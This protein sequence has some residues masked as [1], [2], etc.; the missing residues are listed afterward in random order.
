MIETKYMKD[1][2]KKAF[3]NFENIKASI[4]G[5]YEILNINLAEE[6]IYFDAASDNLS[7]LYH[8][9]LELLVND[10]GL[11]RFTEKLRNSELDLNIVLN[12]N[13]AEIEQS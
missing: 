9:L 12:E 10:Y 11:K 13:L 3:K 5:L 8:N 4:K 2:K 1:A 6:D 7:G